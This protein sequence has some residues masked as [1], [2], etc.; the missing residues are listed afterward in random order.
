MRELS[1]WRRVPEL[2]TIADYHD[3]PAYISALASS[4]RN[5]WQSGGKPRRLLLS[6][7]GLPVRYVEAG[8]P[9]GHVTHVAG[10][11]AGQGQTSPLGLVPDVGL[12]TVRVLGRDGTGFTSDVVAGIEVCK[13]CSTG[14][15]VQ[16]PGVLGPFEKL[17]VDVELDWEDLEEV[18]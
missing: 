6:F 10:I 2:R 16:M 18:E 7:H 1:T 14:R 11:I 8:D 12:V 4:L 17:R 3:H 15:S 5:L 9:Y 13:N